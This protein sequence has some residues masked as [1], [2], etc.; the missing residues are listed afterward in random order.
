MS[1]P[2]PAVDVARPGPWS[3]SYVLL[4]LAFLAVPVAQAEEA[5][6]PPAAAAAPAPARRPL[7]P[8]MQEIRAV[9]D[10]ATRA[11]Q[12]HS[13]RLA[14]VRA[15]S[16]A[17]AIQKD[18]ERTKFE[19][20]V[21]ILRIQATWAR[22]EGRPEAAQRLEAAIADMLSPSVLGDPRRPAPRQRDGAGAAR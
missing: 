22:R 10:H 5:V 4:A 3:C 21:S 20:E 2:I 18:I 15:T 14:G 13:L 6:R 16:E 1:P 19:A 17:T 8:M 11:V 9:L 7:S 12:Q